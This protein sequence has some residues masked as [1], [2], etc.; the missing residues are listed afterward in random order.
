[1]ILGILNATS[2]FRDQHG[3]CI[4]CLTFAFKSVLI[5]WLLF[6]KFIFL[7]DE[8][9]RTQLDIQYYPF[10]INEKNLCN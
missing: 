8:K 9:K 1:M 3:T 2:E 7:D 10:P 4:F 5:N 6:L